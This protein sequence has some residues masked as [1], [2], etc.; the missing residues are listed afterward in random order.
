MRSASASPLNRPVPAAEAADPIADGELDTLFA[1]LK[2]ARRVALAVSGGP[3]SLA[4]LDCFDRWRRLPGRPEA[5]VL[6]VDH[7]LRAGSGEDAAAVSR[8]AAARGLAARVLV[9]DGPRPASGVEAAARAA[10]YGLML[11]AAREE[12]ASH[13]LL[14]HH[15]DDQ[16]ETF[17]M[18]LARGSGVFGLGAMRREA[19]AGEV[20]IVR[21]FLD[22]PRARLAATTAAAGLVPVTDPMNSDP[23]FLRARIR[24]MMPLLAAG[25]ISSAGIAEAARRFAAAADAIDWAASRVIAAAVRFDHLAIAWLDPGPFL[26]APAEVRLRALTRLLQAIGGQPYPPRS[27]RLAA[28]DRGIGE[29]HGRF[30][31]TLAGAVIERRGRRFALYREAGRIGLPETAALGRSSLFWDRRFEITIGDRVPP[32]VMV[33]ALGERGRRAIGAE[34][35]LAPADALAALP[36]IRRGTEILAVPSLSW[37]AAAAGDFVVAA[38]PLIGERTAAPSRFPDI[39]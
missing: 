37:R 31:R 36:A 3:D 24:R 6:S 13:L 25:G 34:A 38:R 2:P 23:R 4:L 5:I 1:D 21:P 10:R 39:G 16:A 28:L 7:R 9:W 26:P 11:R 33:G 32:D 29:A 15:R 30:K 27:D 12:G 8:V 20:T 14:A 19:G 18:R 17:L 35:S 22:L